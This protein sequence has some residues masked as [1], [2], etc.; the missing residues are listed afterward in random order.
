MT[1]G[2]RVTLMLLGVMIVAGCG[3][4]EREAS[5]TEVA[6]QFLLALGHPD[7]ACQLLAPEALSALEQGGERCADALAALDLP[8]DQPRDAEVWSMRAL[9]RT[10]SDTLFL[11]EEDTGWKVTS[12]GCV[13]A[14]DVTYECAL[15]S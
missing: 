1:L 6:N 8:A 2:I 3:T 5:A 11:V 14:V 4:A 13:P 7:Q 12:A 9:V 15:A 10:N